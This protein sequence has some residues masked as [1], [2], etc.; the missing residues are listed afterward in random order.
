MSPQSLSL[1]TI[2][3]VCL[4]GPGHFLGSEQTI[5]RMQREYVYPLVGDRSNPKEWNERG[6]KTVVARAQACLR[7][8]LATHYPAHLSPAIDEAIRREMPV[9]LPLAAMR[10]RS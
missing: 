3:E 7:E 8:I 5:E 9:R 4:T 6:R 10:P 2:R 1:E